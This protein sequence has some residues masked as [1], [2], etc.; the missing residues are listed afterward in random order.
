MHLKAL[1]LRG[2]KSF[3]SAT[4]LKFEPGITCVV[5]PN[6]SGKSNV[7][8]ALS[9]VM[10]EQG[11]KSLRGGK[12]EDVIFAGTTGR[13]PLGRAEVSLTIDN[14]DGALPIE[15]AEVTITR[16]MFRNG[17]SEYQINGDT[18]RLLDIQE[19][20]SDSG[21]GREMHVIVG[22]GQL[23]G[24]LHADPMGRRAF[25]EEAAGVLKHR[26]RKEK[27]LRKLDAMKANLAR[28]QDLTDELRRQLKPLGRQAAV[29]RR[30]AVIQADLRDARLRLLADD[31]VR[32]RKAL[33]AEVADEAAL[34]ERKDSAEAEL[35]AALQREARLEE[36]VR[37][38]T[39]RL[40]RA[41]QTWYELS[42]LAERVRG[43]V[44]L[45]DA[46]VR[47]ATTA[48]PEERR[49]RDPEDMEREAARIREQEAELTAALEAAEHA[50][51]DT[52]AHRADLEQRLAVEERRLKDVARAIA[53][54]REGLARLGGQVN[55]ARSRAASAQ[56]EIDRLAEARDAAAE[57]A[58]TAQ[59]E[60]EQLKAE[61][62][63]LDADDAELGERHDA[64]RRD[65]GEAEAA[66]TAA[67]EA[68]TAAE[69]KRA[70][71]AARHDAL[72]LGLRR[73]DGTGALLSARDQL[74]GVLGPAAELLSV[75]PGH[76][77]QV[78]AALGVAA[79]ALAVSGPGT[80]AEAIRL[81]R[82]QDAGRAAL[83]LGGAP[84]GVRQERREGPPHVADLVRGPQE[85]L[86]AVRRLLAGMVAVGT[87]EDAEDLVYAHPELTAV[88]AEGDLLGAHFAHGGSAGAPSLLEVQ[89]SVDEAA[90]ELEQLAVRCE[91]L[92]EAQRGA[93][94]RRADAAALVE[95]LGERR[96]AADREK[97]SVAQRLGALAGQA[98][99]AAGEAE[100]SAAAAAKA[101]EALDRAVAEAEELAERLAVAEEAPADE[102][103][104]TSVRD[105][106]AA[107]GANARQTE[108]E[109]RLQARTHEE[110]VKGLAG[111]A[112]SL[113]RAARAEREARARAE[114]RTARLRHEATVAAAVAA[115]GRQLLAHVEV[116]LLRAEQERAAA[117]RAKEA[118]ERELAA[119]RDQGRALKAELDKLT[120][121]V[122]R[123]EVLGAEKRLRIEQLETKA[124]EELGVEPAGLV[125]DYGPDQP[126]PPSPAAEGEELPEDP[127]HP[128][129]MPAPFVRAE[130]EKRLRSAERAYQQLGKVNPLALEEFAAL[131]ERHK[132]LS[133]QL[134]DLKKTRADLLQVIR[135]VDERVE[136]VFAEAYRDT[137]REFE[138]VFSRLFPG[139]E[140]RLI[141]TDPD[142]MLTTGVDV[143]ARPPGK[144]VKRL[145]L[146][147]GG[148]R[149][150]TAVALL[151]SIFKARPSPFYVMDEVEAALDDTNLQRLIRIM[152]ELQ[153]A[154]QLIV[155]THQKRTMEIADALYGVSMQ[156]DGVSKVISQR[157]R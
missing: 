95:E 63:G 120:D 49:G 92:A 2:F 18:C 66:L 47:S 27:A 64:A 142:N 57:R 155:I 62:D 130:Q 15:Y 71:V 39:P 21:I 105:R 107:D 100:R 55:A 151:V 117:E 54:R 19:L 75:T 20:L 31:L 116:S 28:V 40:Q 138:G 69:R 60:Y 80:A 143:E 123:G 11:A 34:K 135:E 121:S 136:Q 1:T 157:L 126:V 77:V 14:S 3:A 82:K 156:G 89:A 24:V 56:A 45:A 101:Q 37:R 113:D 104:D 44:S 7:V 111:R 114:R 134:E 115:G 72:A 145:S 109:A 68:A 118:R 139:G 8:D 70:A 99:G 88:T 86:P 128:R 132:F 73:K 50:L 103:P 94:G 38:L 22:Q 141:L 16:I 33:N 61:V 5:G 152:Q 150:L 83:L 153:E 81:L 97:S 74:T 32:L 125:A 10:G 91:E 144:K 112:D 154:S 6:G 42:Q 108:M 29:A 93:A 106:L 119:E 65:L 102:E 96:R 148:E 48:P 41:Q 59:E 13:P 129:N 146:L 30:A 140:G 36:E 79:D 26:K 149:S 17:G 67:R 131:E 43:T 53:D 90:A 98:R 87:L 46:R 25:I 147:S 12:M 122:H 84:D 78:A 127:R 137:A 52:V 76:E 23:D 110:R 4:T 58:V 85:L 35:K 9:W 133:E 124:L 51:D